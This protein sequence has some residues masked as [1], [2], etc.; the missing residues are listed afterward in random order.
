MHS[1]IHHQATVDRDGKT[2]KVDVVE[3]V[4]GDVVHLRVGDVVPADLRLI[5][6]NQLE[7]DE[8]VLTGES[9]A[10]LKTLRP[11]DPGESSLDLANCA[12]MG[13]IVRSG[14]GRGVVV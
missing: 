11:T 6:A 9:E 2:R 10:A 12:F 1:Q 8:S 4:P 14:A 5:D 7:C 13:T 3:L